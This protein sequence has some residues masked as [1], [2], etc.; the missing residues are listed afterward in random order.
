MPKG[1]IKGY[2]PS[3]N[4]LQGLTV[5]CLDLTVRGDKEG[6]RISAYRD[7]ARTILS[8]ALASNDPRVSAVAANLV[9]YLG[10]L[11]YFDLGDLFK[12]GTN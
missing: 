8:V 11:G 2:R 6:W 3:L 9:N 4:R 12:G 7:H 5:E 1:S 10:E